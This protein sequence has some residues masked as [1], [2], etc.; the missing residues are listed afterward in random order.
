M[1]YNGRHIISARDFD[2]GDLLSVFQRT[3]DI[4]KKMKTPHGRRELG[5]VLKHSD[6]APWRVKV[7]FDEPSTRTMDSF[8]EACKAL[9]ADC[10]VTTNMKATSS[11]AKGESWEDTVLMSAIYGYNCLVIR[12]D[13]TEPHAMRRAADTLKAY[14]FEASVINAGEGNIE[15]PTQMVL[16]LYTMWAYRRER[17]EA[18]KLVCAFVGDLADSRTIH[19]NLLALRHFGGKAYLVSFPDNN[20]PDSILQETDGITV[21]KVECWDQIAGEVNFWYFTRLQKERRSVQP[22]ADFERRYSECYG[23]TERFWRAIHPDA[24]VMHPLP[25]GPEIPGKFP[26]L[27]EPRIVYHKQVY[28]GW[29]TRMALFSLLH[30]AR[31][32]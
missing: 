15:H 25:R 21:E 13:G 11:R 1:F 31:E 23:A 19:S 30:E 10:T 9:G 27:G 18:G 2:R 32:A 3:A 22:D 28:Y 14:G 8:R 24:F 17:F 29:M 4:E 6:G 7:M 26:P 5:V 20:V 16:D 12:H